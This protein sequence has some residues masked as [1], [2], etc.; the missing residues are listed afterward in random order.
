MEKEAS[1]M[2][3]RT[4]ILITGLVVFVVILAACGG[5]S[6]AT[7]LP[8]TSSIEPTG[9]QS[10]ESLASVSATDTG[11]AIPESPAPV[12][13]EQ[14]TLSTV[15]VVKLLKPSVVQIVT[16]FSAMGTFNQPGPSVGVGTGIIL[17][18]QGNILTNNHVIDGAQAIMVTLNNG[19]SFTAQL[20]GGDAATDTAVIRIEA[21]SL[22]PPQI[23]RSSE[24]Q[25]GQEVIAIGHALG[26]PG[27]PT[28]SKGVISALGRSIDVDAQTTMVDLI[29]T[30]ASINPGNSGGPLSNASG[31]VIGINSAGIRGSQGI[32][33]AINIDD[34]QLVVEQLLEKGYVDRG[35]LGISPVTLSP[36]LASQA[37]APVDAGIFIVR[38]V[39]GSAAEFA[40]LQAEDVIVQMAGEPILNTGELSKFLVAHLPGETVS[41]VVYRGDEQITVEVTLGERPR[42]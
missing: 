22:R 27:G 33:F 7:P 21:D 14:T 37:G 13:P 18:T 8:V 11:A 20:I 4:V 12:A 2:L 34:A 32:G 31:E 24:L 5:D 41:V 28:V 40:G 6:T 15:D 3:R 30:D 29:Q 38:I 10:A 25:V 35:F 36:F 42:T 23:G 19:E 17:D 26:L 9:G 16:E 39:P 1:Q